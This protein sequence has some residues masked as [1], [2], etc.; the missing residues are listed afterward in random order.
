MDIKYYDDRSSRAQSH[1]NGE[2]QILCDLV[3]R[4]RHEWTRLHLLSV[5]GLDQRCHP[6]MAN[7]GNLN[8][9]STATADIIEEPIQ[10]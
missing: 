6:H 5:Y 1:G 9:V 3:I 8:L 10:L 2:L 4:P 7:C